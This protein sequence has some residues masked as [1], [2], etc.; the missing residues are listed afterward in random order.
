V[1]A[2]HLLAVSGSLRGASTNTALLRA[3]AKIAPPSISM[4]IYDG[5]D[6]L[7]IFNPDLEE[8]E[9]VA[10]VLDVRRRVLDADGLVIACPEYAH[11][12]PGGLKNALDWLVSGAEIPGKPVALF[13]ASPRSSHGRS[14]LTE[15]LRTMSAQ[16][17][18]EFTLP[19]L[20][21]TPEAVA[22]RLAEP[23]HIAAIG[24]ALSLF[25]E[26]IGPP[27][28]RRELSHMRDVEP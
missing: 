22:N 12:I 6:R 8:R 17:V 2:L 23:D 24:D 10:A 13:H 1:H 7:P 4:S 20:G 28:S 19:L 26:R 16:V 21:L 3:A 15:V 11:G 27:W 9:P 14:A 18:F 25:A 5:L